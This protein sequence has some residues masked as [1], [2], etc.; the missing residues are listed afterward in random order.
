MEAFHPLITPETDVSI[1]LLPVLQ[2]KAI[3]PP[4]LVGMTTSSDC[5]VDLHEFERLR[6]HLLSEVLLACYISNRSYYIES[7]VSAIDEFCTAPIS[8]QLPYQLEA[9]LFCLSAISVDA[10]KRALL[11][12][13]SPAAQAAAFRACTSRYGRDSKINENNVGQDAKRHDELLAKCIRSIASSPSV[14]SS[15]P[16]SLSQM[17]RFIG[18][19]RVLFCNHISY[20]NAEFVFLRMRSFLCLGIVFTVALQITN[21][22]CS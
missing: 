20:K 12:S 5:G 10:S 16:L 6:G 7:C 4:D 9:A 15:N 3:V 19:V 13:A 14:A 1:R 17:C 8:P 18:K 21:N 11:V 2:G 22:W